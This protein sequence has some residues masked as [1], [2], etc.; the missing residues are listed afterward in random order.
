LVE[1]AASGEGIVYL[2]GDALEPRGS[3]AKIIAQVVNDK[4]PNWGGQGFAGALKHRWPEAQEDFRGWVQSN[5]GAMKLGDIYLSEVAPDIV[6]ASMVCQKGYGPSATPR[7]RYAAISESLEKLAMAAR[8]RS[9]SIHMPRIG[10][11][12]A[13]GEWRIIEE[14]IETQVCSR[15]VS[16]TVYDLPNSKSLSRTQLSLDLTARR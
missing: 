3:G 14:M 6:V 5:L 12:Q 9:A 10:S 11:G 1:S 8:E 4:T 15:G 13:G 7:I 16:V 2:K